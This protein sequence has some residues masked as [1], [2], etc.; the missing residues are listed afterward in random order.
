V[1]AGEIHF[2][3]VEGGWTV[4]R[5]PDQ[6]AI[7]MVDQGMPGASIARAARTEARGGA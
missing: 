3:P 2:T 5:A 4:S 1:K 7:L 6:V